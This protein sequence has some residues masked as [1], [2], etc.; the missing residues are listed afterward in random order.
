MT[1]RGDATRERIVDVAERL[2]AARGVGGVSLREIRIE[3]G[4]RNV[5]ALQFHFGD[6]DG[7]LRAIAERH[8][9]RID[10]VQETI[11][12]QL[13]D[14]AASDEGTRVRQ[15]LAVL[16]RPAAEYLALGPSE[17]AWVQIAA[18]L[19]ALPT[20]TSEDLLA[21]LTPVALDHGTALFE[22]LRPTLGDHLAAER[23]FAVGTSSLH[24]C[25]DRARIEDAGG[26]TRPLLALAQFADNLLDMA[27]G[28]LLAPV[29]PPA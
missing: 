29:G 13:A 1:R 9:P 28:A 21:H 15:H 8:L 3:A 18:Q 24:L 25:A 27:V 22:H 14:T 16:V 26:A 6:R 12:A 10:A 4:Q 17:R 20:L 5:S 19:A 11:A 7:L 2:Y 23:L